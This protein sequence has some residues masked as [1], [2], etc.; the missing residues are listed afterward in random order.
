MRLMIIGD[1]HGS[2]PVI[3]R[4][5]EIAKRIGGIERII[6]LGDFGYWWRY[7]GVRFLD[8]VNDVARANNVQIF[9]IPGNHECYDQWNAVV[10][11]AQKAHATSQGWAYARSNVLLSPRVHDFVWGSR[12]FV[13]A[14]GAVSIDKEWREEY[15]RK[16][17]KR[18]WSPDEQ[19]TDAEVDG[20]LATRFGN[21]APVDYLLTHDCSNRT[22]FQNR[23]KPD[24]DSQIHRQRIDRVI[25]G[26]KPNM[27]FH[28][29]MHE[30]YEWGNL[31]HADGDPH[32][33]DTYGLE[34]NDDQWSW[35]VLDLKENKV[36]WR[37]TL[38]EVKADKNQPVV[39]LDDNF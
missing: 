8:D 29:H 7:E 37:P 28:G 39:E 18:I 1:T 6:V 3:K 23:L 21:G 24:I 10:E 9:A 11:G 32:W 38:K 36:E 31:V 2:A 19:L 12:Q 25:D 35:L 26:I 33:V 20:L 15:R 27:H 5:I 16:K 14:G 30:K 13:V 17:G 22:P 4:K 34:C